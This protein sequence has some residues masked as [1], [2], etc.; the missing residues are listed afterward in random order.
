MSGTEKAP[1]APADS[2]K[3]AAAAFEKHKLAFKE[4]DGKRYTRLYLATSDCPDG[5]SSTASQVVQSFARIWSEEFGDGRGAFLAPE[6]KYRV[7]GAFRIQELHDQLGSLA[8]T[9]DG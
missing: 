8:V 4:N 9:A 5:F 3:T 6:S 7:D 1:E 2:T